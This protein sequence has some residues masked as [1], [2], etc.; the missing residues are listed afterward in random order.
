MLESSY[1]TTSQ[2]K[3][4]DE[5]DEEKDKEKKVITLKCSM[6]EEVNNMCFITIDSE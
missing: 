3:E 4:S 1:A 6:Q 2:I 5:E